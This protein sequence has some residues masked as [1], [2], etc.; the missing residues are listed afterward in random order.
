M[1]KRQQLRPKADLSQHW[2]TSA[3][4]R[5]SSLLL[6][7]EGS[8]AWTQE[9]WLLPGSALVPSHIALPSPDLHMYG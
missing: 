8:M 3:R 7:R 1:V 4:F 5:E 6:R 9:A 2:T